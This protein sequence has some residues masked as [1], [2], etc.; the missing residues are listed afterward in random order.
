M[1]LRVAMISEHASPVALLGGVDAGGQNVYV[2]AV[3][4]GLA[5][6][7]YEVDVF[8]R[9]DDDRQTAVVPWADGVRVV[10]IPFG[11]VGHLAKDALWPYMP[12]FRDAIDCFAVRSGTTYSLIHGNF[13]MSG[14][15]A[16]ALR[17]RWGVPAVQIFHATGVTKRREQGVADT[18]PAERVAIERGVVGNVDRLTAQCP[19]E[20]R[21]LVAAY[22]ASPD[23]IALIPSAV[24]T[25]LFRT[26]PQATARRRLGLDLDARIVAYVGRIVP[27]KDIRNV[28][29]AFACLKQWRA[30]AIA[31]PVPMLLLVGGESDEPDPA[32]T[33]EIGELRCLAADL[34]VADRL[35]FMGRKQ[36]RELRHWYVAADVAV[37][38][39]WYEPFGLT[40]L[41]AMA[42]GT[43]VVGSRVGGIGFT[44][45]DGE[46]GFLVPPKDPE[47]LARA[48]DALLADAALRRR[49]GH[50][51]RA[52][53]ER[54]FTWEKVAQRTAALYEELLTDQAP[55]PL[56]SY[57]HDGPRFAALAT[58]G[59]TP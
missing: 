35:H 24:D 4:R 59:Q 54:E 39:P 23:R 8:T 25:A 15:V 47:A 45:A 40:P 14:W 43:P 27:R 16:A 13:W 9:N 34:G 36:A 56:L 38:T 58:G 11:P 12:Q 49:M 18:S 1:I 55:G 48:L 19:E 32:I 10:N 52:R 20:A 57:S 6:R 42:C 7:G 5:A 51:G 3:S 33:P 37:T 41:E 44:I 50:A 31:P 17:A 2:D 53:V 28:V 26:E 30:D 21:E 22:G 29:R 46:S